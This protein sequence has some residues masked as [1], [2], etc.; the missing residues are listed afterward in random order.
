MRSIIHV[1]SP[2][3]SWFGGV[4]RLRARRRDLILVLRQEHLDDD[5]AALLGRLGLEG[6]A[7]LPTD[8]AAA[9]RGLRDVDRTLSTHAVDNLRGWY[10]DDYAFLACC[11]DLAAELGGAPDAP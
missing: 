4:D 2:Y 7:A 6:R 9:H 8:D 5:F 1:Q 10:A 11:E 3:S